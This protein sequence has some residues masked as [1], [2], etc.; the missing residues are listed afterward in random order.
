[1]TLPQSAEVVG[2]G[3]NADPLPL[4]LSAAALLGRQTGIKYLMTG[5]RGILLL[6]S[7]PVCLPLTRWEHSSLALQPPRWLQ[8][9]RAVFPPC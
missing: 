2:G 3:W 6:L 9:Q 5:S 7:L 4:G 1:M 8:G